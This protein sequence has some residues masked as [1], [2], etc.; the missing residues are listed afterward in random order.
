MINTQRLGALL[1]ALIRDDAFA[2][3]VRTPAVA[4]LRA[5]SVVSPELPP[6]DPQ[7]A[8]ETA[9]APA[10]A[11]ATRADVGAQAP[12][13]PLR[14]R[15]EPDAQPLPSAVL[16]LA[17]RAPI[18]DDGVATATTQQDVPG[19]RGAPFSVSAARPA[20]AAPPAAASAAL[21]LS[22]TARVL[23]S[24]LRRD[25]FV[26]APARVPGSA[27]HPVLRSTA[28]TDHA[29]V[30]APSARARPLVA[31]PPHSE[32]AT[33]RLA[34]QLK[35]AVEF[36]GV[37][38]ESHLAQWAD[39][40]RP[41]ALLAH[42]PQSRWPVAAD[43]AQQAGMPSGPADYATP[44]LRQQ[45]EVLDSGRFMWTGE[46]WP[47]QRASLVIEE[48]DAP[49]PR[50]GQ[51]AAHASRWRMRIG[52]ELPELGAIDVTLGLAG[53]NVD[54]ALCCQAPDVASRLREAT[55]ALRDAIEERALELAR[56][57]IAD[58]QA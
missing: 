37:F 35:D 53:E 13:A 3:R 45:L 14:P 46:L 54:L 25:G 40:M 8:H 38:Y 56:V 34:L 9:P 11:S 36:S 12:R 15:D 43:I 2:A 16:R 44:V 28:A 7:A 23:L 39:D 50:P 22:D 41:R 47:G 10:A 55:P 58:G 31:V 26:A 18:V 24:A 27:M 6:P 5:A 42:E 49:A 57:T 52:L 51:D 4:P 17:D 21:E 48:D 29:S 19:E 32:F 20:I 1:R 30:P 33:D